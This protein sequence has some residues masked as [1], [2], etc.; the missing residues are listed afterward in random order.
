MICAIWNVFVEDCSPVCL[1][2]GLIF[3]TQASFTAE[4]RVGPVLVL[5]KPTTNEHVM[6]CETDFF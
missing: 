4:F 3:L 5:K 6:F 1:F 2:K